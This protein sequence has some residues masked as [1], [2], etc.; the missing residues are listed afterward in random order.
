M[1]TVVAQLPNAD[2]VAQLV[3][4]S[5]QRWISALE[6]VG[7]GHQVQHRTE[8]VLRCCLAIAV[9]GGNKEVALSSVLQLP[10]SSD[11]SRCD[12]VH[13]LLIGLADKTESVGGAACGPQPKQP[14]QSKEDGAQPKETLQ[15]WLLNHLKPRRDEGSSSTDAAQIVSGC[16]KSLARTCR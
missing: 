3:T 14:R 2:V 16:I 12:A 5:L 4:L 11:G 7:W 8:Y 9:L 15:A 1:D 13:F 6:T 10:L